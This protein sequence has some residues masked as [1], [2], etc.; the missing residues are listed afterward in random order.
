MAISPIGSVI[1]AQT[2]QEQDHAVLVRVEAEETGEDG[3]GGQ[4][5]QV[6]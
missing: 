2:F 6:A 5:G 4:N 1:V 3:L